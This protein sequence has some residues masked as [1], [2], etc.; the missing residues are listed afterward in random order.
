MDWINLFIIAILLIFKLD[1][2][3]MKVYDT[4][5]YG[6]HGSGRTYHLC[7]IATELSNQGYKVLFLC[8]GT[9]GIERLRSI[10]IYF[11]NDI[12]NLV[13][14]TYS[15]EKLNDILS[16]T[17]NLRDIAEGF[18]YVIIDKPDIT[19]YQLSCLPDN[20]IYILSMQL[21][22]SYYHLDIK[23]T[24]EELDQDE[25]FDIKGFDK[26]LA[27]HDDV[28]ELCLYDH[29]KLLDKFNIRVE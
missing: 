11:G 15:Y 20:H 8:D 19:K 18:D 1:L 22:N 14:R 9:D 6:V 23:T 24:F 29:D 17:L 27:V 25:R 21:S 28:T 5:I 10:I 4:I 3:K 12:S 26:L 2:I 16:L 13:L 7:K